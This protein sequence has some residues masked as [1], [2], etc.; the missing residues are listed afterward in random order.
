MDINS[1]L[2]IVDNRVIREVDDINDV[3]KILD[4]IEKIED[5]KYNIVDTKLIP[6]EEKLIEHEY[7]PTIINSG[8]FT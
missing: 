8:E 1:K 6:K 3:K 2:S 7:L 5:L 4:A